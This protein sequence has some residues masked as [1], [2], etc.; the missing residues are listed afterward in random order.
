ME[1]E[2]DDRHRD[3]LENGRVVHLEGTDFAI[4]KYYRRYCEL[5]KDSDEVLLNCIDNGFDVISYKIFVMDECM[6]EIEFNER[7]TSVRQ[8]SIIP[9]WRFMIRIH[10]S[11]KS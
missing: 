1:D 6:D 10:L 3:D 8:C 5:I 4:E 2:N 11:E 7:Y 9:G